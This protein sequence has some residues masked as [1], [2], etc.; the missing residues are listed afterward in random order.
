MKKVQTTIRLDEDVR[1]AAERLCKAEGRSLAGLINKMLRDEA[2]SRGMFVP[3]P[4][5]AVKK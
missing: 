4:L 5:R 1:I 3:Q 2:V